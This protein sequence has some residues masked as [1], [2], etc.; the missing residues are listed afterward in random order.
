[1]KEDGG[2]RNSCDAA[3]SVVANSGKVVESLEGKLEGTLEDSSP[4]GLAVGGEVVESTFTYKLKSLCDLQI[5][6]PY[7]V[8]NFLEMNLQVPPVSKNSSTYITSR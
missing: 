8:M 2:G 1:M 4:A 5:F 7:L 6:L 3:E